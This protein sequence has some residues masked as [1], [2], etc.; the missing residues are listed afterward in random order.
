MNIPTEPAALVDAIR[1]V[2]ADLEA[3]GEYLEEDG[4][5][6]PIAVALHLRADLDTDEVNSWP[7]DIASPA[8]RAATCAILTAT[9]SQLATA[10]RA[11]AAPTSPQ[12]GEAINEQMR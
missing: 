9:H 2:A 4:T 6:E 12:S 1:L 10:F 5:I 7:D 8:V 3:Q 11:L